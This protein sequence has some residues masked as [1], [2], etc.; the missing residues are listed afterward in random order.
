MI[1][2]KMAFFSREFASGLV[3][4]STHQENAEGRQEDAADHF[5]DEAQVNLHSE[6]RKKKRAAEVEVET[7]ME[8]GKKMGFSFQAV[9]S[10]KRAAC[11]GWSRPWPSGRGGIG[12]SSS[13]E[14]KTGFTSLANSFRKRLP[15]AREPLVR[16][17]AFFSLFCCRIALELL[18]P[19]ELGE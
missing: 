9:R 12:S 13:K 3:S 11:K 8:V 4:H 19:S 17:S 18:A 6:R 15:R 5:D 7:R 14:K 1:V 10:R 2:E 16:S